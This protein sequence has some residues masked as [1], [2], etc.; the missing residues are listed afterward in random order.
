MESL[1]L[2]EPLEHR[3]RLVLL[4]NQDKL[5]CPEYLEYQY[6]STAHN[7]HLILYTHIH[8]PTHAQ[9][10]ECI[11]AHTQTCTHTHTQTYII[12]G[13]MV[14]FELWVYTNLITELS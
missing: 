12:Y 2:L 5:A 11:N 10:H 4:D 3:V 14:R 7:A 6:D 8:T 9:A 1:E 13:I